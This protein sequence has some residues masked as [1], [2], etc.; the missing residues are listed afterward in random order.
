MGGTW[1][2]IDPEATY[3]VVSNN[4]MRGGGDGY[5]VFTT[6]MNAY[7]FGPGLEEVVATMSARTAPT[8]PTPM[9]G[10]PKPNKASDKT[11]RNQAGARACRPF[12]CPLLHCRKRK[13]AFAKG[14]LSFALALSYWGHETSNRANEKELHQ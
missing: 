5:S 9:G 7:D 13:P 1:E 12:S 11:Q 8:R 14:Q 2:A 10:F 3:G 4:F 6:A